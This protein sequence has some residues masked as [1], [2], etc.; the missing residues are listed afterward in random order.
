M[1]TV[2][3]DLKVFYPPIH[4]IKWGF[5][6]LTLIGGIYAVDVHFK[7][8]MPTLLKYVREQVTFVDFEHKLHPAL[9]PALHVLFAAMWLIYLPFGHVFQLFFRYYHY[10]RWDEVTNKPGGE[11]EKRVKESLKRPVT[12]AA[13]HISS[14]KIWEEV[15]TETQANPRAST[16]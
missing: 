16:K 15:A 8:N 7:S 12:W 4:Y 11:V 3:D 10:L 5:I 6:L 13:Q 1:R 14:G 2:D 9:A